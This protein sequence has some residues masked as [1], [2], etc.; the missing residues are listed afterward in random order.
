MGEAA[1]TTT[2]PSIDD[3][4][5]TERSTF[6][7]SMTST[8]KISPGS[9]ALRR[10]KSESAAAFR[11]PMSFQVPGPPHSLATK[12]LLHNKNMRSRLQ[13]LANKPI[14]NKNHGFGA[15]P[16]IPKKTSLGSTVA[17]GKLLMANEEHAA[18]AEPVPV[19]D[20]ADAQA[21]LI[22][23]TSDVEWGSVTASDENTIVVPAASENKSQVFSES[24]IPSLLMVIGLDAQG[25]ET[26]SK[27]ENY[28]IFIH[29]HAAGE[30]NMM[31]LPSSIRK[32]PEVN[33]DPKASVVSSPI[34][35]CSQSETE[36][37]MLSRP[38][39]IRQMTSEKDSENVNPNTGTLIV[40]TPR[41]WDLL[42]I[43]RRGGNFGKID[44]AL[45]SPAPAIVDEFVLSAENLSVLFQKAATCMGDA[46]WRR[47]VSDIGDYEAELFENGLT[48]PNFDTSF[49]V[50]RT[51]EFMEG[52]SEHIWI[53]QG[54]AQSCVLRRWRLR[55]ASICHASGIGPVLCV[56]DEGTTGCFKRN[57][58]KFIR[59]RDSRVQT[60]RCTSTAIKNTEL[61]PFVLS[62]AGREYRLAT[63]SFKSRMNWVNELR[64][65]KVKDDNRN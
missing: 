34:M 1:N 15:K 35:I 37:D 30:N 60:L 3:S 47:I 51:S 40:S 17:A 55:V 49:S 41:T 16:P 10:V 7:S 61:F 48:R 65:T 20:K 2:M 28:P 36:D 57:R 12:N 14:Q 63:S 5:V 19:Q 52:G 32:C 56:M 23:R 29:P 21:T 42:K 8:Y 39:P 58:T 13:A 26:G 9:F 53:K 25:V 38:V 31:L 22:A 33:A 11:R 43:K 6:P 24:P 44:V 46:S 18:M 27:A 45:P 62:S 4:T 64:S 50:Q 59:L 54:V